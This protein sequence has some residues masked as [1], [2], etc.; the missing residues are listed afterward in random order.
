MIHPG[1]KTGAYGDDFHE[2]RVERDD[3]EHD[4][5]AKFCY[6]G[7]NRRGDFA[8]GENHERPNER[9]ENGDRIET[10]VPMRRVMVVPVKPHAGLFADPPGHGKRTIIGEQIPPRRPPSHDGQRK[11]DDENAGDFK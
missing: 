6:G 9:H 8:C 2:R 5:R 4:E 10:R 7:P 1:P 11:D 3:G